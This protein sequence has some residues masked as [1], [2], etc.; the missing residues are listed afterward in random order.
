MS[1][2]LETETQHFIKQLGKTGNELQR[3]AADTINESAEEVQSNYRMRLKKNAKIRN[4][5]ALNSVKIFKARP[6]SRSGEPRPLEKLDAVVFMRKMKGGKDH[7]LKKRDEGGVTRGNMLTLGK[8]PI[9][10]AASRVSHRDDKPISPGNRLTKGKPQILKAG[11]RAFGV[12]GDRRKNGRPWK[13]SG[14][15]FAALYGYAKKANRGTLQG[16]LQKPFFFIDNSNQMGVFKFI[17][18]RAR[19]IRTL[20]RKKV[21][22]KAQPDFRMSVKQMTPK[23]IQQRFVRNAKRR[24]R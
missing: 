18:G 11:G 2:K 19:K 7:F 21:R 12:K 1:V 22:R 9:P 10:L 5:F 15:R 16:D 3:V 8:V 20:N 24:I 14:Q 4:K 6:V 13:S 17:R 23:K